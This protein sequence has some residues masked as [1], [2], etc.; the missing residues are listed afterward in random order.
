VSDGA[1]VASG[2]VR[3]VNLVVGCGAEHRGISAFGPKFDATFR[4]ALLGGSI[5]RVH[6]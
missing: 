2:I 4:H 5:D 3:S 1:A 6:S